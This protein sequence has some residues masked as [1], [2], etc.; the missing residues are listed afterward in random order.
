MGDGGPLVSLAGEKKIFLSPLPSP[1]GTIPPFPSVLS[2]SGPHR[3]L[4]RGGVT[5]T[6]SG[7]F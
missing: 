4:N 2:G 7:S 6:K 3:M 5:L 1:E